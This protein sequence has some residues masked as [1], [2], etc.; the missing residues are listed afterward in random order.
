M[1]ASNQEEIVRIRNSSVYEKDVKIELFVT[2]IPHQ[3]MIGTGNHTSVDLFVKIQRHAYLR[4][5]NSSG[6]SV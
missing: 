5:M 6:V 1:G 4:I 3:C 2:H